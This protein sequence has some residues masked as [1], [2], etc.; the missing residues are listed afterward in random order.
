VIAIGYYHTVMK[1]LPSYEG[2]IVLPELREPV[3][4]L[5]DDVGV[6]RID[7]NNEADLYTAVGYVHAQE[8]L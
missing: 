7:A 2:Q 5:W 3:S 4:I 6:P 8:R 1:P